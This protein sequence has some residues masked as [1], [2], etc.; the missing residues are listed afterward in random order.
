[1]EKEVGVKYPNLPLN[2][3]QL[4]PKDLTNVYMS[5]KN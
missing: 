1:M 5:F 3:N 2:N 4:R